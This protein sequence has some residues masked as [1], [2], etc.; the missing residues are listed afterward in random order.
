MRI[1]V[2]DFDDTLYSTSER[3]DP[4]SKL[5]SVILNTIKNVSNANTKIYIISN[6]NKAW[7]DFALSKIGLDRIIPNYA[8]IISV[9]DKNL[10]HDFSIWKSIAFLKYLDLSNT[11]EFIAF[12]DSLFDREA[13]VNIKK[14]YPHIRVK[15]ILFIPSP[16]SE[17]L[18]KEHLYIQEHMEWLINNKNDLDLS[19]IVK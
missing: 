15:N 11:D 2:F 16:T 7:I 3:K 12:G 8:E 13:S 19:I 9:K 10:S 4:D 18:I 1:I 6:A 14:N 5:A 17:I